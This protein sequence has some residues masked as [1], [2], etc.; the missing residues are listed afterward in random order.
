MKSHF[1]IPYT[2]DGTMRFFIGMVESRNDPLQMGRVQVRIFGFHPD[3]GKIP[4]EHL[5]WASPLNP[6]NSA[7]LSGVGTSPTG[8]MEGTMVCG[9]WG[10]W[11][12]CQVPII[13]GTFNLQEGFGGGLGG[14][15]TNP[16]NN[17][18]G[19]FSDIGPGTI[20]PSG[21]GPPWLQVARGELNKGIVE[22]A[23]SASNPEILKYGREDGMTTDGSSHPWCGVF[24]KWCCKAAGLDVTGLTAGSKSVSTS[25]A[26]EQIAQP[27][28]GCIA[29]KNRANAKPWQGHVG[30]WVG[31]KG[32]SDL[33]LG[34]NQGR[35]GAV[36]ISSQS[37]NW[38]HGYWWPKGHSKELAN[39]TSGDVANAITSD[40]A[41]NN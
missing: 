30:F 1:Q 26:F 38:H 33:Y 39:N 6:I 8:M 17:N 21:D 32:G 2:Q 22:F 9:F 12:D 28:Y 14:G 36:S 10:D 15:M 23:G 5:P 35:D 3:N 4:T 31:R 37:L 25:P 20:T 34:G 18:I 13:L 40:S 7:S 27:I 11:P 19:D 24:V 41:T 29:T 16:Y